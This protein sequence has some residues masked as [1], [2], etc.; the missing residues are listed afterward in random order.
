MNRNDGTDHDESDRLENDRRYSRRT[1]LRTAGAGIGA[2]TFGGALGTAA[3]GTAVE[4]CNAGTT[5]DVAPTFTAINNMWSTTDAT[6]CIFRND[7]DSYGWHWNRGATSSS[8]PNYPE[9][10]CGTKPWGSC[11]GSSLFPK[12][13]GDFTQ[14][15]LALSKNSTYEKTQGEWNL[16]EEW[17]LT[18]AKPG[19]GTNVGDRITHEVMLVLE[20]SDDHNHGTPIE[21]NATEDRFGNTIDYWAHYDNDWSFHIFRIAANAVPTNVDLKAVMDYMSSNV[22]SVTPDLW[23]TGIEVGNEYWDDTTGSI[24]WD[25]LDVTVNGTTETSGSTG[26]NLL[27]NPGFEDGTTGWYSHASLAAVS[28]PVRSGSAAAEASDRTSNWMGVRQDVTD[29]LSNNGQG[30]YDVSGFVRLGSGTGDARVTVAVS[31]DDGTSYYTNTSTAVDDAGWTEVADSL[32]LGWNGLDSAELYF[33][34]DGSLA[35]LYV[36][37]AAMTFEG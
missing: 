4:R 15:D 19:C 8:S 1:V 16:A 37:D 5:I 28:S 35:D 24:T 23:V 26:G 27:A 20:W 30:T 31:D 2:V 32:T 10:L 9:V 3:A 14:L 17:W 11:T 21:S 18:D 29:Q 7:D 13:R 36:D 25:R 6:Q 33:E 34:T 12:R 22:A